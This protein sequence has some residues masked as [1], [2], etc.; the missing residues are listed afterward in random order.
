[1]T[2]CEPQDNCPDQPARPE[3]PG[4]WKQG[5][6]RQHR[7]DPVQARMNGECNVP[8][9]KL[10]SGNQVEGGG[11]HS[12]PGRYRRRVQDQLTGMQLRDGYMNAEPSPE[13]MSQLKN[14]WDTESSRLPSCSRYR[15]GNQQAKQQHR[16][17]YD[18]P[19]D[20][21]GDTDIKKITSV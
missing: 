6:H 7:N 3:E 20:R 1:M 21:A 17:G 2:S 9:V 8:A 11:K 10:A 16:N 15:L 19:G 18:E 13:V 5:N 12:H 4:Q 14:Q